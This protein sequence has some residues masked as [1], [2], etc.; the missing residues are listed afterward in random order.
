[1]SKTEGNRR[2]CLILCIDLRSRM[3]GF[4][5]DRRAAMTG[6]GFD[7]RA[8]MIG[9]ASDRRAAMIGLGFDLRAVM[10]GLRLRTVGTCLCIRRSRVTP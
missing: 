10:I 4:A 2:Y 1:V 3:T 6:L 9:F 5:S 7:L 8:V